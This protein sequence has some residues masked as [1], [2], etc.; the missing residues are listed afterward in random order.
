MSQEDSCFVEK[1]TYISTVVILSVFETV[2][3]RCSF[4]GLNLHED[5]LNEF[6]GGGCEGELLF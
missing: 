1:W 6:I 3:I 2:F 5:S 4:I